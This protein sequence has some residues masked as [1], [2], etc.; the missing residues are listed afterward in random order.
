[1]ISAHLLFGILGLPLALTVLAPAR[2]LP[3]VFASET[4]ALAG[5]LGLLVGGILGEQ[6]GPGAAIVVGVLGG[7]TSFAW[8]WASPIGELHSLQSPARC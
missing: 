4:H 6:P 1:M 2:A 3:L 7:L 5:V 8:L